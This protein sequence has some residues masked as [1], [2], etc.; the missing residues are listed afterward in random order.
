MKSTASMAS[1]EIAGLGQKGPRMTTACATGR[2]PHQLFTGYLV[3]E[4]NEIKLLR[5]GLKSVGYGAGA[6]ADWSRRYRRPRR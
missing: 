2:W 4:G 5:E 1:I 6:A 3:A